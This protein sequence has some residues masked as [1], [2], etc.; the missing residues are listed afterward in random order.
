MKNISERQMNIRADDLTERFIRGDDSRT[1]EGSGLG[2]FIAKSFTE[3]QGG[4]F[5]I[6]L[7]GD[8]FKVILSFPEYEEPKRE[9][10]TE[11]DSI[12]ESEQE[13]EAG[14]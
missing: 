11:P 8:L 12:Q 1:T 4:E 2:L 5:S 7:D 13:S 3:V 14:K 10:S 6:Q 9:T